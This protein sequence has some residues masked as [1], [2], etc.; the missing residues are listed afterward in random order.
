ML[1]QGGPREPS[2][3][4]VRKVFPGGNTAYGFYSFYDQI[5]RPDANKIFVIKGG[6]G[7]G[8]STFM[9]K[10]ADTVRSAGYGV[11]YH[12]C[13]SDND[14]LD[15][16]YVPALDVALIDGTAP[17]V[18]DPKN[19]GAVDEIVHLGDYW[20]EAGMRG[21][22]TEILAL[23]REVGRL[24]RRAY[25][26]L[27]AAKIF[28][29]EVESYYQDTGALDRGGLHR[30]AMN[31]IEE[32]F[33]GSKSRARTPR[34]RHLFATAITPDGPVNYLDTI[35]GDLE[36][37]YII[38]GDDG[39]GKTT[40]ISRVVDAALMRGFDIEVFHCALD[41]KK[42]DHVVVPEL[43]VAVLNEVEPHF[44]PHQD[45]DT[46]ID[47][48]QYVDTGIQEAYLGERTRA[49][50]MYRE[51]FNQAVWFI[52]KAKKTHDEMERYYVPNMDFDRIE[53]RRREVE[54]RI[55]SLAEERGS[56]PG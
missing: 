49:R 29:D 56:P 8:K 40:V 46:R 6:P 26:Y 43:G 3:G 30:V 27:S 15:G 50:E 35:V 18:V 45:G 41:P 17:H 36:R 7:V 52:S 25:A 31:L 42:V 10:I 14:S 11:E 33:G 28:L 55:M 13:S 48:M 4:R 53:S 38:T 44:Y 5:A 20:D 51:A 22:R 1:D 54:S 21:N 39:T 9:R 19:P 12:C 32:V 37:H 24:F 23:N 16:V 47:T 34:D 2:R